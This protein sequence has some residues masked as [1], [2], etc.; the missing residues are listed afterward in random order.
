MGHSLKVRIKPELI[1]WACERSERKK[2]LKKKFKKLEAWQ[3]GQD[4]PTH[5]QLKELAKATYTPVGY[6]FLDQIPSDDRTLP[7]DMLDMRTLSSSGVS[8]PSLDLLDTIYLCQ[9]RQDWYRNYVISENLEPL[10]FVGAGN[11][12][13]DSKKAAKKLRD[14]FE[15]K[16][17]E[18][19][20]KNLK[21]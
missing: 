21:K 7:E 17:I 12:K 18:K 2:E 3:N 9:R 20:I 1:T 16:R 11:I 14:L 5:N 13:D 15:M 19:K 10:N 6:F 4:Q 8:N